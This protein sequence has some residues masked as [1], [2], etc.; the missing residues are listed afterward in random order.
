MKYSL[1]AIVCA[2]YGVCER[3]SA[4]RFTERSTESRQLSSLSISL[5]PSGGFPS[6]VNFVG[7]NTRIEPAARRISDGAP[8]GLAVKLSQDNLERIRVVINDVQRFPRI[9]SFQSIRS[10]N[11]VI[12]APDLP[13]VAAMLSRESHFALQIRS[14]S[15]YRDAY[16]IY[17]YGAIV[18]QKSALEFLGK[19]KTEM[20]SEKVAEAIDQLLARK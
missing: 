11:T 7:V 5:D 2:F 16:Y 18:D 3:A 13:N 15:I 6:S 20:Q 14:V 10:P 17:E 19:L 1:L 9:E 12:E 4:E 8:S